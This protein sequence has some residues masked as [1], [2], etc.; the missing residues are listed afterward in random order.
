MRRGIKPQEQVSIASPEEDPYFGPSAKS[1]STLP[2][3]V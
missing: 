3:I 1:V 2:D